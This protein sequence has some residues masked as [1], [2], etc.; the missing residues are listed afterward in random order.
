MNLCIKN[1]NFL[2][3][4]KFKF[5]LGLFKGLG[6]LAWTPGPFPPIEDLGVSSVSGMDPKTS[7]LLRSLEAHIDH[8]VLPFKLIDFMGYSI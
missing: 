3:N 2:I 7:L 6:L 8:K 5:R 1:I 4:E